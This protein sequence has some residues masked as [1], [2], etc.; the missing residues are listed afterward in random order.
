MK[1][2]GYD[3]LETI[4]TTYENGN[5]STFYEAVD[6]MNKLELLELVSHLQPYHVGLMILRSHFENK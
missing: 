6:K 4:A 1:S 5:K 3:K 2:M